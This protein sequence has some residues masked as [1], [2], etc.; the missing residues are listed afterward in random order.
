MYIN[1]YF[2]MK[3]KSAADKECYCLFPVENNCSSVCDSFINRHQEIL[4]V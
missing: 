3:L 4:I 1:N 2:A